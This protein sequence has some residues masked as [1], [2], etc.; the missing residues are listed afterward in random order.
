MPDTHTTRYTDTARMIPE[1]VPIPLPSLDDHLR[2]AAE[3][4][5]TLILNKK[6]QLVPISNHQQ[7]KNYCG[8]LQSFNKILLHH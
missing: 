5:I 3:H 7:N 8:W 6:N 1:R 4:L 2:A